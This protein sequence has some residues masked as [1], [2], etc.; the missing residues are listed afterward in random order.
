MTFDLTPEEV[1]F[2]SARLRRHATELEVEIHR[3][4]SLAFKAR[5]QQE[6][7]LVESIL[8]KFKQYAEVG[9]TET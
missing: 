5:L 4:D 3:T 7:A 6:D 1:E 8:R 9:Q 2:L